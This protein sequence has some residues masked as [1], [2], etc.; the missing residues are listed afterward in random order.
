RGVLRE[1]QVP[2][3]QGESLLRRYSGGRMRKSLPTHEE[4]LRERYFRPLD[5]VRA[6]SILLVLT[7]HV[8]SSLWAWLSGWE[9][10]SVFFVISGFLITTLCLR[11]EGRD[12]ARRRDADR[13]RPGDALPLLQPD[14]GR[15]PARRPAPPARELRAAPADPA[16]FLADARQ[17]RPRARTHVPARRHRASHVRPGHGTRARV[18][19]RRA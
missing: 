6:I 12:A 16:L 10:P 11:E 5:G 19:R 9:G 7:W 3:L 18:A 14:H 4:Y 17:P 2:R 15:V 13:L 8:N 1:S